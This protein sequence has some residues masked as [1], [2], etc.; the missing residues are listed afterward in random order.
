MQS[1]L[2]LSSEEIHAMIPYAMI[3]MTRYGAH[4]GT[5]RRKRRWAEEFTEAERAA[6]AA[7]Y[8]K[9]PVRIY[10]AAN[11]IDA[12]DINYIKND[13]QHSTVLPHDTIRDAY[14][15]YAKISELLAKKTYGIDDAVRMLV[16]YYKGVY[17]DSIVHQ[18]YE[19]IKMLKE[20]GVTSDDVIRKIYYEACL[21]SPA[22]LPQSSFNRTMASRGVSRE[23]VLEHLVELANRLD[24]DQVKGSFLTKQYFEPVARAIKPI[25]KSQPVVDV[26]AKWVAGAY[27]DDPSRFISDIDAAKSDARR[28]KD[29]IEKKL[30]SIESAIKSLNGYLAELDVDMV[31]AYGFS[32]NGIIDIADRLNQADETLRELGDHVSRVSCRVVRAK[33]GKKAV[34]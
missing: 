4:W 10:D 8:R 18:S 26:I 33:S 22:S 1:F 13:R 16:K 21:L 12:D 32:K 34:A 11:G 27:D 24:D 31:A 9:V 3:C 28:E 7:S 17:A 29:V 2:V 15:I 23:S 6:S 19:T 5:G 30:A 14:T 25:K 20:N